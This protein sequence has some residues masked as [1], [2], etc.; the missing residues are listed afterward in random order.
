MRMLCGLQTEEHIFWEC[1]QY[2]E[3]RATVRDILSGNSK[4]SYRD[5][6]ARR[7]KISTRR[8]LLHKQH[9]KIYLKKKL[10]YKILGVQRAG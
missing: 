10:M 1:K 2:E 7:K 4:V 3:Q 9:F 5:L 8:L 6:N